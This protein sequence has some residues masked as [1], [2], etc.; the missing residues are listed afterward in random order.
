MKKSIFLFLVACLIVITSCS[1]YNNEAEYEKEQ[2]YLAQGQKEAVSKIYD[3]AN[4]HYDTYI[5][6][7]ELFDFLRK[8]Y[9]DNADYLIEKII[10]SSELQNYTV[11][12]I[13]N[14]V[15]DEVAWD[16]E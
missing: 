6:T 7:D 11:K 8:E 9:G 16:F 2:E 15:I 5:N 14:E 13:V 3:F 4:Y 1:S 10:F 12:E